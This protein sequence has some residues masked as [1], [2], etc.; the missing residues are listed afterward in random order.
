MKECY[1][2]IEEMLQ[3]I[4]KFNEREKII[5]E[6]METKGIDVITEEEMTDLFGSRYFDE[7]VYWYPG[8]MYGHNV[9]TYLSDYEQYQLENGYDPILGDYVEQIEFE[10][11]FHWFEWFESLQVLDDIRDID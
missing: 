6:Y 1:Y 5:E 9:Y 2:S 3:I 10:E 11:N 4:N 7:N 8:Y